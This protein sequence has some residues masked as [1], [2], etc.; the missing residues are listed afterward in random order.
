MITFDEAWLIPIGSKVLVSDGM[1]PPSANTTGRPYKIWQ[2]NN[3]TGTIEEKN[4]N[5][6]WRS[7]KIE[8]QSEDTP[9]EV[10]HL[11]YEIIEGRGH[12]FDLIPV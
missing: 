12:L 1:P 4:I 5:G 3:F 7:M 6:S 10:E 8:V 11:S 2:S 9:D